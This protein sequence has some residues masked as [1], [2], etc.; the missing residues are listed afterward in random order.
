MRVTEENSKVFLPQS[1]DAKY[2]SEI[3]VI[4]NTILREFESYKR[5]IENRMIKI[6]EKKDKRVGVDS[7]KKR[8]GKVYVSKNQEW[9][10]LTL[11]KISQINQ[12]KIWL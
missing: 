10:Y 6:E 9:K 12:Q 5:E 11:K 8:G 7:R 3:E 1:I 4:R 2:E